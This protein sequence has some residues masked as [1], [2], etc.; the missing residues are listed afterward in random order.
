MG[1]GK[2]SFAWYKRMSGDKCAV[3]IGDKTHDN[4]TK[5]I[6]DF[7]CLQGDFQG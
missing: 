6:I 5:D 3:K 1:E 7:V 2:S 4:E